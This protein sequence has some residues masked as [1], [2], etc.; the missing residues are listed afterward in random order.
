MQLT[1][2]SL[3]ADTNFY[4]LLLP[5]AALTASG[6]SSAPEASGPKQH[7]E[8]MLSSGTPVAPSAQLKD[9]LSISPAATMIASTG[10]AAPAGADG[11]IY[12]SVGCE[13]GP[14]WEENLPTPKAGAKPAQNLPARGLRLSIAAEPAV[15]TTDVAANGAPT[16]DVASYFPPVAELP[17]VIDSIAPRV[18]DPIGEASPE[19]L[20]LVGSEDHPIF[21]SDCPGALPEIDSPWRTT[22]DRA[23]AVAPSDRTEDAAKN[24]EPGL[25]VP[26]T[27]STKPRSVLPE[28]AA[29]GRGL[30]LEDNTS[31]SDGLVPRAIPSPQSVPVAADPLKPSEPGFADRAFD[32]IRFA[33]QRPS[34]AQSVFSPSEALRAHRANTAFE[35]S[36]FA[37]GQNESPR[38]ALRNFLSAEQ[39]LLM[40]NGKTVGTDVA[41][42]TPTMSERFNSLLPQ[43]STVD[44]VLGV[45]FAADGPGASGEAPAARAGE[46]SSVSTARE[47]VE[48]ALKTIEQLALREQSS[49]RL[50]FEVGDAQLDVQV[51]LHGDEVRTTFR[52][53]SSELRAALAAE[54]Q[55]VV[56]GHSNREFRLAQAVF[57]AS[58]SSALDAFAGDASSRQRDSRASREADE[59]VPGA[60]ASMLGGRAAVAP[61][62]SVAPRAVRSAPP[63]ALRLHTLA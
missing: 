54:W 11:P 46:F 29:E 49:V 24:A 9:T 27:D 37:Q 62:V 45:P 28:H 2:S 16:L 10:C 23:S 5:G 53:A 51:R 35:S 38:G 56:S 44:S 22:N 36:G 40:P 55:T 33:S 43:F 17:P 50:E 60:V 1:S 61:A 7:F 32:A 15:P 4:P 8:A 63:T 34:E 25:V 31:A 21:R 52:T 18:P 42:P 30:P 41:K 3:S 13:A 39:E 26:P 19:A 6:T 20:D 14:A 12:V 57:S 59:R 47:A 58:D 48:V